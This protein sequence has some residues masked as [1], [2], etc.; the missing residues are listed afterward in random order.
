MGKPRRDGGTRR[1]L[2]DACPVPRA[3]CAPG[4][5]K[6]RRAQAPCPSASS[7]KTGISRSDFSW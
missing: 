7:T 3:S 6:F 1:G 5:G 2:N 4:R